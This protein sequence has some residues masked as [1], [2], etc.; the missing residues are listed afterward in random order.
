VKEF[1]AHNLIND[2]T[3][4]YDV[5]VLAIVICQYL[6]CVDRWFCTRLG[7]D[8]SPAGYKS[9]CLTAGQSGRTRW[10]SHVSAPRIPRPLW[11]C[12]WCLE[13]K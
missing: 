9:I 7:I 10:L 12:R 3:T 2:H 6:I 4:L 13:S 8:S 5:H 11:T 1:E